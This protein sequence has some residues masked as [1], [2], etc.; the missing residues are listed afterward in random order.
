MEQNL[1]NCKGPDCRIMLRCFVTAAVASLFLGVCVAAARPQHA[2]PLS[3]PVI[4]TNF[5]SPQATE[6]KFPDV[7]QAMLSMAK[8]MP[9]SRAIA[10]CPMTGQQVRLIRTGA[11]WTAL[12]RDAVFLLLG[13]AEAGPNLVFAGQQQYIQYLARHPETARQRPK[14]LRLQ[15]ALSEIL[16]QKT[17][18]ATPPR[19]TAAGTP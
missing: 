8:D 3:Q 18:N 11:R 7:R 2:E 17:A 16:A 15:A 12:P 9:T 14:P 5:G 1:T 13:N 10:A 6:T 4:V 19:G